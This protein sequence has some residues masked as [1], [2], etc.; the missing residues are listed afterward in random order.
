MTGLI[1]IMVM[2]ALLA[3]VADWFEL[4]GQAERN[5]TPL[6]V[7]LTQ[8]MRNGAVYTVVDRGTPRDR[9]NRPG[10][11]GTHQTAR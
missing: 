10:T 1:A 6:A 11:S 3:F 7:R 8:L 9:A 5:P 4:R 2:V